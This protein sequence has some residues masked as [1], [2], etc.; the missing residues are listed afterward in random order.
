MSKGVL[1]GSILSPVILNIY[2]DDLVEKLSREFGSSRTFAYADD[3]MIL[4]RSKK[5]IED[6]ITIIREWCVMN[7][8]EL[9]EKKS[10]ILQ[11]VKSKKKLWS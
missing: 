9:N 11:I 5:R 3:I 1:Q 6:A 4:T 2:V 7:K 10:G 8:M